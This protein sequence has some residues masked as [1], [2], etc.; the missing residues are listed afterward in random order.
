V[1]VPGSAGKG[2]E[3][4]EEAAATAAAGAA[5]PPTI[6]SLQ[7]FLRELAQAEAASSNGRVAM[8]VEP[9]VAV[10]AVATVP[11]VGTEVLEALEEE[12]GRLLRLAR[13]ESR[14]EQEALRA[15]MAQQVE[16]VLR[17]IVDL[18][19]RRFA[20]Q[21]R[22]T[23]AELRQLELD[24]ALEK[25][26]ERNVRLV[27]LAE[28][29]QGR[30]AEKKRTLAAQET[31]ERQLA[32]EL[33]EAQEREGQ[34]DEALAASRKAGS[35]HVRKVCFVLPF[36]HHLFAQEAQLAASQERAAS[37]REALSKEQQ[38]SKELLEA[39]RAVEEER[40]LLKKQVENLRMQAR[41]SKLLH[42]SKDGSKHKEEVVQLRSQLE[43]SHRALRQV[44]ESDG[45][46]SA[47][48]HDK[49]TL[50]QELARARAENAALARENAA[51][52]DKLIRT[53]DGLRS[54]IETNKELRRQL[55][56]EQHR[57]VTLDQ[58]AAVA[59]DNVNSI[60]D[61]V[62]LSLESEK[63][64]IRRALRTTSQL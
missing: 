1:Y 38:A 11:D 62:I 30:V 41:N 4:E 17:S 63:N 39:I 16:D 23:G 18:L 6:D 35:E 32:T 50:V 2:K 61:D 54:L 60:L 44:Q 55:Q 37:K 26:E 9:P 45:A 43:D 22:V 56:E 27:A 3:E 15:A 12:L 25:Q 47:L 10:A 52:H 24:R 57:S 53:R 64:Q 34:L 42:A 31:R 21:A 7:S 8:R 20:S 29:T 59:K 48:R 28:E 13:P 40:D 36:S 49:T 58:E 51:Q 33:R 14:D 19:R 5:A 46:L